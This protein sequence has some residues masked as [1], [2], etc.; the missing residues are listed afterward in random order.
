MK[1]SS[2]E[3]DICNKIDHPNILKVY[4]SFIGTVGVDTFF[5]IISEKAD[6][7]MKEQLTELRN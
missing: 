2:K 4:F 5:Y 1:Q 3:F 6:K 7:N